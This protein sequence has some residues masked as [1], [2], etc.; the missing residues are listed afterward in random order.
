MLLGLD[1]TRSAFRASVRDW[2]DKNFPASRAIELERREHEYPVVLWDA[3][4]AA[5]YHGIGIGEE[6]GGQGGDTVDTAILTREL[7]RT[8]GGLTWTWVISSFAGA[9]LP[10]DAGFGVK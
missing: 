9:T 10:A 8:L 2:A 3:L 1:Q 4:T 6:Y 7:A 5:G